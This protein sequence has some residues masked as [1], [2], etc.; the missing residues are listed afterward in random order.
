MKYILKRL[1]K[2]DSIDP[3]EK[4]Q[5]NRHV[6]LSAVKWSYFGQSVAHE[7][8]IV[9]FSNRGAY[10]ESKVA[11][12]PGTVVWYRL[13]QSF[14]GCSSS[15]STEFL[16]TIAVVDTKWC[17]ELSTDSGQCYGVGLKYHIPRS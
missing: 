4:R 3:T 9:N 2:M 15:E 6:C 1:K 7:G 13:E 14:S 17:R 11:L 16:P 12:K 8:R 10:L 5:E